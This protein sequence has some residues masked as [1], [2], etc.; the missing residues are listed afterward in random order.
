MPSPHELAHL[1]AARHGDAYH[2][3][4]LT[5]PYR[6]ELQV[7]CY[8]ML[9]SLEDA[10]DLVQ[11]TL[12]RA[13]RSLDTFVTHISFRAW[14]YKIATNA[15]LDVLDKR[16]RRTLPPVAHLPADPHEP[17]VPT[18]EAFL[19]LEPYP[20]S[21]L[22]NI[23]PNPES[24][25][26]QQESI[27]LAFLVALQSLPPRQRAV[28][29]LCDVLAWPVKEVAGH[30][31][32][33]LPAANSALHRARSTLRK[34]YYH[35]SE[36]DILQEMQ[37]DL[38]TQQVLD[39]YM[40]AWE[41][42]DVNSLV[43]LLQEDA[44]FAMPPSP[45]WYWGREAIHIF[46]TTTLFIQEGRQRW[47]LQ[48]SRAN[49]Q[50]AFGLYQYEPGKGLYDASAIQVLTIRGQQIADVTTFVNPALFARFNLPPSRT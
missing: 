17:H 33:T 28:L 16:S 5:E 46:L 7:H 43:A 29:L 39:R 37:A 13:W 9:G 20:D 2:F 44:T 21:L 40:Q 31:G 14:L 23:A 11:E 3:S 48:P 38:P 6:A 41:T 8:R 50:P 32:M 12:L 49:A 27:R 15:C 4:Q 22:P 1:T 19:W 35:R 42:A 18:T 24:R 36:T 45:S 10:E 25:Y 34:R 26:S 30:L 47:R